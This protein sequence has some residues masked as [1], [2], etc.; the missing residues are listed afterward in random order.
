MREDLV[1]TL[2]SLVFERKLGKMLLMFSRVA[3]R[4]YEVELSDQFKTFHM[5]TPAQL[6]LDPTF[7]LD[8][9]SGI[10]QKFMELRL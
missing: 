10:E 8:R 2:T 7:R 1:E 9:T 4:E 3:T 6:G 5:V